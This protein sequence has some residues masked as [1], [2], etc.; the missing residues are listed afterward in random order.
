MHERQAGRRKLLAKS[1][2]I[3]TK[4]FFVFAI[5]LVAFSGDI[6]VEGVLLSLVKFVIWPI[7]FA[8]L[9]IVALVFIALFLFGPLVFF[10]EIKM[11]IDSRK[12]KVEL[13]PAIYSILCTMGFVLF[14]YSLFM[15]ILEEYLQFGYVKF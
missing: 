12:I 7:P 10:Y 2:L 9:S 11:M 5:L 13:W 14:A 6:T 3:L 15:P 1:A 8:A 4:L